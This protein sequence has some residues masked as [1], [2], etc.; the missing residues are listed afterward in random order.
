VGV[1]AIPKCWLSGYLATCNTTEK[2]LVLRPGPPILLPH[3]RLWMAAASARH[4]VGH[5]DNRH[6]D[7]PAVLTS[8][9]IR[10]THMTADFLLGDAGFGIVHL[11]DETSVWFNW[12]CMGAQVDDN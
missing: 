7:W 6:D 1:L 8:Q 5:L 3:C 4:P 10:P 11:C 2:T 9:A 12:L